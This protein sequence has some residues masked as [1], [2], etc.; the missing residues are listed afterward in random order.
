MKSDHCRVGPYSSMTSILRR[1]M[2]MKKETHIEEKWRERWRRCPS[3]SQGESR[4][5][6]LLS[7]SS[8]GT[9]S[10]PTLQHYET[11]NSCWMHHLICDLCYSSLSKLIEPLYSASKQKLR[12]SS[13]ASIK[14]RILF[15][16]DLL[17]LFACESLEVVL[18]RPWTLSSSVCSLS[19]RQTCYVKFSFVQIN[20]WRERRKFCLALDSPT[21]F[22]SKS[23]SI[24]SDPLRPHEL[25]G[26]WNSP[27][28][29]TVV[30]TWDVPN[31]GIE[32]RSLT[33]QAYSLPAELPGEPW[34][35]KTAISDAGKKV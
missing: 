15:G 13:S 2:H 7:Q 33:L 1:I 21:C 3:I 25:Y 10:I 16:K 28:Q 9:F 17:K 31:P 27:G 6:G 12:I 11:M 35:F 20:E 14:P 19:L 30:G 29:N 24:M 5:T 22:K 34:R 4:G 18:I 8:E 32:S 23:Y 26:S